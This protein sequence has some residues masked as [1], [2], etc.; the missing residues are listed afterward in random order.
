MSDTTTPVDRVE[1]L[2]NAAR[3]IVPPGGFLFRIS[4]YA[5]S[6][7]EFRGALELSLDD[8]A[9]LV[10]QARSWVQHRDALEALGWARPPF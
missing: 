3:P 8:L 7:G 1:E 5:A 10:A 9:A 4:K 6:D 2:L